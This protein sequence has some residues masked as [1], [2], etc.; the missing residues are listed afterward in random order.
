MRTIIDIQD[1]VISLLD[2]VAKR[3]KRSRASVVREAVS[4][5]LAQKRPPA[6]DQAFGIWKSRPENGIQ[7]QDRLRK[8]WEEQI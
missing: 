6:T 1:D 5:Y 3:E 2:E 8:E 7:Y 4:L